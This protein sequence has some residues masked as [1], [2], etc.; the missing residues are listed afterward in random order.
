MAPPNLLSK[1]LFR[2]FALARLLGWVAIPLF[3]LFYLLAIGWLMSSARLWPAAQ[4]FADFAIQQHSFIRILTA[5][6]SG[7]CA[8]F[9]SWPWEA[10][11]LVGR[12]ADYIALGFTVIFVQYGL[13][14]IDFQLTDKVGWGAVSII[15]QIITAVVYLC[16]GLNSLLFLAAARTL[17]NKGKVEEI[18]PSKSHDR[19][20][21]LEYT[22]FSALVELRW[23]V[24]RWAWILACLAPLAILDGRPEFLWAR[25]PN[26]IFSA[27][28]LTLLGYAIGINLN[29]RRRVV[30]AGLTLVIALAYGAG[31]L[32]YAANPV[33]SY[34]STDNRSSSFPLPWIRKAIGN[35][36]R[37]R[38]LRSNARTGRD[39][40]PE[41]FLDSAIYVMLLPIRFALFL[42][43]FSLYLLFIVSINDFRPALSEAISRRKDYLSGDGVVRAIGQ[44]LGADVVSLFI[45]LPGSHERRVLPLIWNLKLSGDRGDPFPIEDDPLLVRV[46]EQEGKQI[47]VSSTEDAISGTSP[48]L[49]NFGPKARLLA[50]VQ[51]HGGVI[52]ALQVEFSGYGKSNFTTLQKLSLMADL[53][54]PSVQD[55][56]ALAAIDQVGVRF[57]RLQIDY[58]KDGLE[59]ATK[60]MVEVMHDVLSPLATGLVVEIGFL[61]ITYICASDGPYREVL[62]EFGDH[63]TSNDQV[64][65]I[66]FDNDIRLEKRP[67]LIRMGGTDREEY[68]SLGWLVLAMRAEKD[69][70][71]H[72][73]L[74]AHHL[75]REA[76]ASITADALLASAREFFGV[77]IKTLGVEFNKESLSREEWF[78]DI[79][80]AARRAGLS[81]V[82]ATD[83]NNQDPQGEPDAITII[84]GISDE[85]KIDLFEQPLSAVVVADSHE[86][87]AR[88]II[89]LNLPKSKHRLWFGVTRFAFSK[90]LN[91]ESPWRSFLHDLAD[92]ADVA[93]HSIHERQKAEA[94]KLQAAQYQ[95]VMAIAVT[96]GT[97]MHQLLNMVRDQLF[98]TEALEEEI[99]E[100]RVMLTPRCSNLLRAMRR[101]AELMRELTEAFKGV[102]KME[103]RR[104][105][106][107]RD[108]AEQA[109]RLFHVSLMQQKI[110]VRINIPPEI[111]ADVPFYI[112]AFTLANVIGNAKDAIRTN[113]KIDID[114]EDSKEFILCHVSNN[115]PV[116]PSEVQDALFQFGT[117]GKQGHNG[118][119]LYFVDKSLR[120]NGGDIRLAYSTA[121]ATRFTVRLPKPR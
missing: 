34:A 77:I 83:S 2:G 33:I 87:L 32:V 70:F 112:A 71:S 15:H 18:Q 48:S 22:V 61:P 104:P 97:L 39:D 38:T 89:R 14:F 86:H 43:A 3:I 50:P 10:R 6:I 79:T 35:E 119:G 36:V 91:F 63:V 28:C 49:D 76:T 118:W 47:L 60:R 108:A 64:P 98:A 111:E 84:S 116:I 23:A 41:N 37:E 90:E 12:W 42:T 85:E 26:A 5:V 20:P 75:S 92:V 100:E 52:G 102:T 109:I 24:P 55:F 31:Q 59:E 82:V 103:D 69:E 74:A 95:G 58:P 73:T 13:S 106:F 120:E 105:C 40:T 113:G 93:L 121:A 1:S 78:E 7:L 80:A 88:C 30:L 101:S 46:M 4:P 110:E 65:S 62:A 57:A 81:W 115:G 44:S 45:R 25:F 107:V 21:A 8:F 72:P 11:R 66:G 16:S 54:A 68:L 29:V 114:A 9:F 19:S 117:S 17:L 94:E 27:Y 96:T 53:I 51:F 99:Y 56:R 67:M